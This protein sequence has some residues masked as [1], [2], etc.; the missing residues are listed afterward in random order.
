MALA[1]LS[2]RLQSASSSR[3]PCSRTFPRRSANTQVNPSGRTA[4]RGRQR[5]VLRA[6]RAQERA[7]E[8]DPDGAEGIEQL[9]RQRAGRALDERRAAPAAPPSLRGGALFRLDPGDGHVGPEG[10]LL[11]FVEALGLEAVARARPEG[12]PLRRWA[13]RPRTG[14]GG[15]AEPRSAPL[16]SGSSRDAARSRTG[17]ARSARCPSRAGR[18]GNR[19]SREAPRGRSP[20]APDPPVRH[21]ARRRARRARAWA[22]PA[23]RTTSPAGS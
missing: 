1:S 13:R 19:G 5:H 18:R 9:G 23:P 20:A 6:R 10:P 21:A 12:R 14:G 15:S 16:R 22:G 7:I 2:A 8:G 11:G 17:A 4:N 3:L